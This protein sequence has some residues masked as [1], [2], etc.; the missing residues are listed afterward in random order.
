[1]FNLYEYPVVFD[2]LGLFKPKLKSIENL[3]ASFFS[4]EKL[5]LVAKIDV[6]NNVFFILN[7]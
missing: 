6:I 1:M 7:I 4:W 2:E 5:K 3:L